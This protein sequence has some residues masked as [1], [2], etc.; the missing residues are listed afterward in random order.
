MSPFFHQHSEIRVKIPVVQIIK[1]LLAGLPAFFV[2]I[3]IN[4]YL[5][6]K[7]HWWK[8]CAYA[9]SLLL[10]VPINFF[11]CRVF[12]FNPNRDKGVFV[13]FYQFLSAV[14]FFRVLDWLT[15]SVLCM[16]ID[17]WCLFYIPTLF[18]RYYV[19][20]QLFN[21]GLFAVFKY[22]FCKRAIEGN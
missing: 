7:L 21:V 10:L 20:V 11:L 17:H 2:G 19:C 16:C 1:F 18:P 5:V 13:Q 8:P 22:F 9:I 3:P 12:V 4:Y 15:Y 14:S 6:S